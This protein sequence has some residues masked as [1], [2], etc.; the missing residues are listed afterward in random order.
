M[1]ALKHHHHD[2][3]VVGAATTDEDDAHEL[4]YLE[5]FPCFRVSLENPGLWVRDVVR[6]VRRERGTSSS[7]IVP[8]SA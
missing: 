3:I 7:V 6:G 4:L 2:M 1:M 8:S 5:G